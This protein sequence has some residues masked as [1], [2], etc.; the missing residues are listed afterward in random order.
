MD[1]F[2]YYAKYNRGNEA[3]RTHTRQIG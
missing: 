2:R 1:S 3:V